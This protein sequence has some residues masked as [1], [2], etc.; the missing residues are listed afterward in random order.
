[1]LRRQH[2]GMQVQYFASQMCKRWL[3]A[4]AADAPAASPAEHS[5]QR[6]STVAVIGLPNA[7]KSTLVNRLIGLKISGVSSKRNTTVNTQLGCFT[8]GNSQVLLYDTPGLVEH[9]V[10][11]SPLERLR[12]SWAT[13]AMADQ[14]LLIVDA[15]RQVSHR[16]STAAAD[17]NKTVL[18]ASAS[19]LVQHNVK[20]EADSYLAC[21]R[22]VPFT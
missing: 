17:S 10:K 11:G 19:N 20:A 9:H 7:G 2:A 13:A 3:S 6:L 5:E 14:L 15:E 21:C 8:V 16:G 12:S 1:M 18:Q 22:A 4:A